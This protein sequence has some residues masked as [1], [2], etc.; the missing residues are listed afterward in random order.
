MGKNGDKQGT[1]VEVLEQLVPKK[2]V[3]DLA[4]LGGR[5]LFS[6]EV[7][8]GRPNIPDHASVL[9]RFEQVLQRH[10]D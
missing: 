9:A 5:P 4:V 7:Y 6:R 8:V 2:S 1:D 10:T 3:T